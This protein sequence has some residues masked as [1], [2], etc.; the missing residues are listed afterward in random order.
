M[1]LVLPF[2]ILLSHITQN[3]AAR[4]FASAEVT[5]SVYSEEVNGIICHANV[6][7]FV[8]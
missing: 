8:K 5:G 2:R 7:G 4:L 3:S 6:H 1:L